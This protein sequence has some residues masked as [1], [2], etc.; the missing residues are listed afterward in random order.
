MQRGACCTWS[1]AQSS[2]TR[3]LHAEGNRAPTTNALRLPPTKG[4][5]SKAPAPYTRGSSWQDHAGESAG[6]S[7][8]IPRW[9]PPCEMD[10]RLQWIYPPELTGRVVGPVCYRFCHG[11]GLC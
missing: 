6:S 2:R 3:V 7:P 9:I 4:A 10:G 11:S 1:L 8:C 5:L